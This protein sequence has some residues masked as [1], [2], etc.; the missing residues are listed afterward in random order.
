MHR[1]EGAGRLVGG[2]DQGWE[3]GSVFT[4]LAMV[5]GLGVHQRPPESEAGSRPGPSITAL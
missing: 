2:I 3:A 4:W 5:T 1:L